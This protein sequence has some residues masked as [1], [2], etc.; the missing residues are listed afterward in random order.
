[1]RIL[2]ANDDGIEA[3][4]I[5]Q[6]AKSLSRKHEVVV[7]APDVQRSAV[8]HSTVIFNPIITR[9]VK[10]RDLDIPAYSITGMPADCVRLGIF[11]LMGE[12]PDIVFS[13]INCGPNLGTDTLYSGTVGAAMEGNINH[14]RSVAI[15]IMSHAPEHYETAAEFA[16]VVAEWLKHNDLPEGTMLNVN[17]PDVPRDDIKG[18]V[19]KRLGY[20]EYETEYV[21]G[22]NPRGELYFWHPQKRLDESCRIPQTDV[23]FLWCENGNIVIT[24]LKW[25]WTDAAFMEK[26]A[27]SAAMQWKDPVGEKV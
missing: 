11:N 21:P 16:P 6:L 9:K 27:A 10:F 12:K 8:A 1:M 23:D 25:D 13:G 15:S 7:V 19:F 22:R 3:E 18:V 14:I 17:V 26:L 2:V 4:G 20:Y 5:Y 24:P